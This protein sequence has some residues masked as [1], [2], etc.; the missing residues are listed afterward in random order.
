MLITPAVAGDRER[1]LR[2]DCGNPA[3]LAGAFRATVLTESGVQ[4]LPNPIRILNRQGLC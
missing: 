3:R 2:V 4:V 1:L